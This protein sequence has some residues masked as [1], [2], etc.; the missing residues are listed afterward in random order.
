MPKPEPALSHCPEC[1]VSLAD[2]DPFKHSYKHW[3]SSR[4]HP[5]WSPEAVRRAALL[6]RTLSND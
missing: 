5:K 6:G 1:Q 3:E 4:N 2:R